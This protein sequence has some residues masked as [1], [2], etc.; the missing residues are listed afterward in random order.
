MSCNFCSLEKSSHIW[1]ESESYALRNWSLHLPIL[2][3]CFIPV[4]TGK[5]GG[6]K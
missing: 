5:N 3:P 2:L 4:K 6:S 1:L